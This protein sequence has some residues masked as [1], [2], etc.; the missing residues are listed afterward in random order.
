MTLKLIG[1][2]NQSFILAI[3]YMLTR[4]F[5]IELCRPF[6][7]CIV[8]DSILRRGEPLRCFMS[9]RWGFSFDKEFG[10]TRISLPLSFILNPSS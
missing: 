3:I 2:S 6:G 1:E 5:K 4:Q 7:A 10:S 9:P 8:G